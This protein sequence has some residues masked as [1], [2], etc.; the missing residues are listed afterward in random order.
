M[1]NVSSLKSNQVLL[2]AADK[3]RGIVKSFAG[4][5]GVQTN[6]RRAA[7]ETGAEDG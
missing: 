1:L 5:R 7:I 3:M 2:V 6:R 4:L